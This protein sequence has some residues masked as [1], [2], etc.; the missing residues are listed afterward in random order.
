[1]SRADEARPWMGALRFEDVPR[2]LRLI[3]RAVEEG[4]RTH[5]GAR[6]RSAVFAAYASTLFV[7]APGP[8]ETIA[9]YAADHMIAIAQFDPADER[10][11]AMFV[12]AGVQGRGVGRALLAFV[13]ARASALGCTR[14]HGAMALNAVTFYRRAGFTTR[15]GPEHL[16]SGGVFIPVRRME[17]PLPARG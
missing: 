8:F 2:A 4:C 7:E 13:E 14:I 5:Y 17:K 11:R 1:M 12:D 3:R 9:A 10:L 16:T 6:Q 15:P